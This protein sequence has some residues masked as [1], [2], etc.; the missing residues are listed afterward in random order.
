[1]SRAEIKSWTFEEQEYKT[2]MPKF[3]KIPDDVFAAI[4]GEPYKPSLELSDLYSLAFPFDPIQ[5]YFAGIYKRI[6]AEYQK[7]KEITDRIK[8]KPVERFEPVEVLDNPKVNRES[9]QDWLD[10]EKQVAISFAWVYAVILIAGLFL[11]FPVSIENGTRFLVDM[12]AI[13]SALFLLYTS[14]SLIFAIFASRRKE[15]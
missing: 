10:C 2:E 7:K 15:K 6:D 11:A 5:E 13:W 1:M 14:V 8:V 9:F 12:T 3:S 4:C